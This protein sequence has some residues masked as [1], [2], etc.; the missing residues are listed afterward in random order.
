MVYIDASNLQEDFDAIIQ[1]SAINKM[2]LNVA[3]C[4]ILRFTR[5][6]VPIIY[7]YKVNDVQLILFLRN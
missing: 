7:Q 1:R 3:K 5:S 4:K 2:P 6:T